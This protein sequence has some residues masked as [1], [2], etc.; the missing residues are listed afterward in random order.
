MTKKN[1]FV[2]LLFVILAGAVAGAFV[3]MNQVGRIAPSA[4]PSPTGSTGSAG[5]QLLPSYGAIPVFSTARA[6]FTPRIC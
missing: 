5:F 1:W 4:M 6:V 3:F 2:L